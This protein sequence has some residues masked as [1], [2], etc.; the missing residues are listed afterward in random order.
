MGWASRSLNVLDDPLADEADAHAQGLDGVLVSGLVAHVHANHPVDA[1]AVV[2]KHERVLVLDFV[3][4][5]LHGV[6]V[7]HRARE[8]HGQVEH[9]GGGVVDEGSHVP[10]KEG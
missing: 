3:L 6:A 5:Q 4:E 7:E 2:G 8:H 9:D 10:A 1:R